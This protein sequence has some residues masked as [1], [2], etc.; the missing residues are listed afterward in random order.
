MRNYRN[1]DICFEREK[2]LWKGRCAKA[3]FKR[4]KKG[5]GILTFNILARG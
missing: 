1:D 5:Q 3:H 2:G 4:L